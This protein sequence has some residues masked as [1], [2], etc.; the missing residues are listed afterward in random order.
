[1]DEDVSRSPS[2]KVWVWISIDDTAVVACVCRSALED[3]GTLRDEAPPSM[4]GRCGNGDGDGDG[5][6]EVTLSVSEL[7]G[8]VAGALEALSVAT[9]LAVAFCNGAWELS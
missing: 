8:A 9:M 5:D 2:W 6:G 3:V 7:P 4:V 1:M